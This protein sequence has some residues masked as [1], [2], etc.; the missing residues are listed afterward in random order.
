MM[1]T[2]LR[3]RFYSNLEANLRIGNAIRQIPEEYR[4][5]FNPKKKMA[6]DDEA[7]YDPKLKLFLHL[8]EISQL[9]GGGDDKILTVEGVK[10][11]DKFLCRLRILLKW[12]HFYWRLSDLSALKLEPFRIIKPVGSTE[13]SRAVEVK[14]YWQLKVNGNGFYNDGKMNMK[15][16]LRVQQERFFPTNKPS[17]DSALILYTGTSRYVFNRLT[18]LCSEIHLDRIEPKLSKDVTLN[19]LIN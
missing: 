12:G 10:Q 6:L 16:I 14:I 4:T 2:T 17:S 8:N 19:L 9:N 11:V 1:L 5:F 18:G 15:S 13:E 3:R 7:V